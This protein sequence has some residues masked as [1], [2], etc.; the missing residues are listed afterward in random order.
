MKLKSTI[1]VAAVLAVGA[2][3]V[4]YAAIPSA[5]GVVSACKR[6]DGSIKL[7]PGQRADGSERLVLVAIGERRRET[8]VGPVPEDRH[9][10]RDDHGVVRPA[11]EALVH[12]TPNGLRAELAQARGVGGRRR[13][14]LRGE[15][16]RHLAHPQRVAA[17]LHSGLPRLSTWHAAQ[18]ASSAL[19][20]STRAPARP[21]VRRGR[22]ARTRVRGAGPRPEGGSSRCRA[23][24]R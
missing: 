14:T 8:E 10:A 6:S 3:G 12:R 4:G 13:Q 24:P 21:R 22:P 18:N 11:G 15:R 2:A 9:G 5:D 1:V 19:V 20:E 17:A 7:G 23:A 16:P